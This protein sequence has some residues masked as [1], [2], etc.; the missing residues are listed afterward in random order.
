[1]ERIQ[2]YQGSEIRFNLLAIHKDKRKIIREN[3]SSLEGKVQTIHS[4]LAKLKGEPYSVHEKELMHLPDDID[5]LNSMLMQIQSEIADQQSALSH[6]EHK[7]E[8]YRIENERRR[9][10]YVP[11]VFAL[12][13][14]LAEK[15]KLEELAKKSADKFSERFKSKQN[16]V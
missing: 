8:R 6:E 11:F 12:L 14:K 16:S 13:K 10:N 7:H 4:K 1:M 2:R 3:I 9:F 15:D 5:S